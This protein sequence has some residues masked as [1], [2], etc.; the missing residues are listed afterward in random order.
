VENNEVS[1]VAESGFP[2]VTRCSSAR[3]ARIG[4]ARWCLESGAAER[5]VLENQHHEVIVVEGQG[6]LFHPR[7]SGVTL[8]CC[9]G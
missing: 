9:T 3:R 6:S 4:R 8:G 2:L 7:Y 1:K 5:L